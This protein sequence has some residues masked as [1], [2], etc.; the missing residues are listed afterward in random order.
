M[1]ITT[2]KPT[3]LYQKCYHSGLLTPN[4]AVHEPNTLNH[5]LKVIVLVTVGIKGRCE[6]SEHSSQD[7]NFISDRSER[8]RPGM[9]PIARVSPHFQCVIFS[10]VRIDPQAS[11][12]ITEG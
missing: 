10:R 1:V 3:L 2:S 7:K 5:D 6:V 9:L 11:R 12:K 4:T 8:P